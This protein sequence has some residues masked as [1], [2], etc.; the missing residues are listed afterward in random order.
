M[1]W[2]QSLCGQFSIVLL[3]A[4]S[5][6]GLSQ[7]PPPK[8]TMSDAVAMALEMNP[9]LNE[10]RALL[11]GKKQEW[12]TAVGIYSPEIGFAREGISRHELYPFAEQRF[13]IQQ[14]FD[15]PLTTFYRLKRNGY[16][17]EALSYTF[18][19]LKKE[20][21]AGV[22][23]RY[24]NVLFA[25]NIRDLRRTGYE[26]SKN[27]LEAVTSR[28]AGGDG[29]HSDQLTAEIGML[30]AE[31]T[32]YDAE[33][34]YH[35]ARY[36]LFSY[37]GLDPDDQGYDIQFSD[38]LY[39]HSELITEELA[40]YQMQKQPA[41]EAALLQKTASEF[42]LREAKSSFLPGIR[43]GY[44]VQ[45]FGTGYHFTGFESGLR[46]P[47]WGM[48][49]QS[50]AVGIARSGI[51]TRNWQQKSVELGIKEK[52]EIAWHSYYTSQVSMDLF[53]NRLKDKSQQLLDLSTEDYREGRIDRMKFLEAQQVYLENRERFAYARHNYYLRLIELEQYLDFELIH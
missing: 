34:E 8:L 21:I 1:K 3:L 30:T 26:L 53:N 5:T 15:F 50:G 11:E 35:G 32:Q 31:N 19:A 37:I 43:L 40:L 28:V 2:P 24:E 4:C 48:F 9:A 17:K 12:K 27:M 36:S 38:S 44:L 39:S 29:S 51:Q 47:L 14:E 52:I 33:R 20:I 22:K 23:S 13:T 41:Y 7:S 6:A 49:E 16:E 25:R 45:D 18:E 42:A 46:I 10:Q